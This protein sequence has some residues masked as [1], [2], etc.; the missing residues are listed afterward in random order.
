MRHTPFLALLLGFAIAAG[1]ALADR[2]FDWAIVDTLDI[3]TNPYWV[4]SALDL[5]PQGEPIRAHLENY[6][7]LENHFYMGDV[8]L[9]HY[10]TA[11]NE[12]WSTLLVG[13]VHVEE[14]LVD[15]TG[16]IVLY[17]TYVDTLQAGPTHALYDT[18][19][20]HRAY[21]LKLNANHDVDYLVDLQSMDPSIDDVMAVTVD[22]N[23]QVWLG[24]SRWN[25]DSQILRLDASGAIAQTI[26]QTNAPYVA[27]L[28]VEP[29]GSVWASGFCTIDDIDFG[30]MPA[31]CSFTY[32]IYLVKYAPGGVGQWFHFVEDITFQETHL[33]TDGHG[34]AYF[35]GTLHTAFE[36]PGHTAEGP[37]WVYDFFLCKV[38]ADGTFLWLREVLADE[39]LG[40]ASMGKSSFLDCTPDGAVYFAGFSR[41][42]VDWV[43]DGNPPPHWDGN[44]A[45]VLHYSPDGDCLW[46]KTAGSD[47]HDIAD[48]IGVDD[49]GNVFIAGSVH[50]GVDFDGMTFPA[51]FINTFIASLPVEDLTAVPTAAHASRATLSNHPNPFNPRT[52][53][54]FRLPEAGPVRLTLH[55]MRGAHL[56]TLAE[57]HR[58]EGKHVFEWDARDLP[59]GV[60]LARLETS[61]DIV[62]RRLVLLR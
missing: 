6:R 30:G 11:G 28:A 59:S 35:A 61:S 44:D 34:N 8:R 43:G 4:H 56:A 23:D 29:D 2:T 7:S 48:A 37:D 33:I 49:A 47:W 46:A 3:T 26:T 20:N 36:F 62:T 58:L 16:A 57:G 5:T 14:L 25:A 50:D 42:E 12:L 60:Y 9:T 54:A 32:A 15:S 10:D 18:S 39:F 13:K 27:G 21:L 22:A 1:P 53:I 40:D 55:D 19:G 17:G 41:G 52:R 51:N 45:L 31:T 24:A 38:A